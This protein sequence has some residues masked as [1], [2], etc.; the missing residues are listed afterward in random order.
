M[1]VA[2]AVAVS[3]IVIVLVETAVIDEPAGIPAPE[4]KSPIS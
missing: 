1:F 2:V 3:L 4:I